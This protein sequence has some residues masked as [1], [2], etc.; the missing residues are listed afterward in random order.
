VNRCLRRAIDT[1]GLHDTQG[2][3]AAH[4]QQ[5]V[6]FLKGWVHGINAF[7]LVIN[8]EYDRFDAGK[9]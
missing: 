4:V 2:V 5:M 3:D 7:A 6:T 8:G 1:Q 9:Q